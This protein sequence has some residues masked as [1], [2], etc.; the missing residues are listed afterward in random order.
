MMVATVMAAMRNAHG[1]RHCR[2]FNRA[3]DAADHCAD[4]PGHRCA[5]HDSRAGAADPL[6]RRGTGAKAQAGKTRHEQISI[7][8]FHF[9]DP[10]K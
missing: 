2:T 4:R 9:A 10:F 5:N 3:S 6:A 7:K 8:R 1:V